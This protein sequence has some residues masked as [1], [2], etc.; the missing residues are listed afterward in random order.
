MKY[1]GTKEKKDKLYKLLVCTCTY[2]YLSGNDGRMFNI[3]SGS[4]SVGVKMADD[5][6]VLEIR[7]V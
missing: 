6:D 7:H 1:I 3:S 2:I 4:R 5:V